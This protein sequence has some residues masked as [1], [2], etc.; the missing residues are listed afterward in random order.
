[1]Y[2]ELMFTRRLGELRECE[3]ECECVVSVCVW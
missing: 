1:M 2:G 3:C